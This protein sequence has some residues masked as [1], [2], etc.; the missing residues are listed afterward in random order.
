MKT[1]ILLLST[2]LVFGGLSLNKR[3]VANRQSHTSGP[4]CYD[5]KDYQCRKKPKHETHEECHVEYDVVV[6]VTYIEECEHIE[7][8]TCVEEK[9]KVH[10]TSHEVGHDSKVVDEYEEHQYDNGHYRKRAAQAPVGIQAPDPNGIEQQ[11]HYGYNT[12][13]QCQTRKDKQCQKH[14]K[15]ESHKVPKTLCKKIVDT[16][17]IEECEEVVTVR[18]EEDL[19]GQH[20]SETVAE[21]E[22][23]SIAHSQHYAEETHF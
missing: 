2:S 22:S 9:R 11:H 15:E 10:K 17:Y 18:C 16:I 20:H 3:E 5:H 19:E 4:Y 6:D 8:T 13:P 7:V 21:H 1:L 12:G 14:P 23:K